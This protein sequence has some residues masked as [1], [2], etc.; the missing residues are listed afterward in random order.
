MENKMQIEFKDVNVNQNFTYDNKN[1][2]KVN[3]VKVSC[4]R[5]VNCHV[6]GNAKDRT[7]LQPNTKVEVQN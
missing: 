6:V 7:F 5:S 1:Y 3:T 2:V 4:C